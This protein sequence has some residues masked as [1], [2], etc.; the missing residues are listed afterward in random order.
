VQD[1]PEGIS[2]E[3]GSRLAEILNQRPVAVL[4][5]SI[6]GRSPY[7]LGN[8]LRQLS[9]LPL[10]LLNL[11]I[12]SLQVGRARKHLFFQLVAR[13]ANC[14]FRAFLRGTHNRDRDGTENKRRKKALRLLRNC[15]RVQGRNKKVTDQQRREQDR[16]S[17]GDHAPEPHASHDCAKK[18][19]DERV[20]DDVLQQECPQQRHDDP[21]KRDRSGL[22]DA[23][24]EPIL[25]AISRQCGHGPS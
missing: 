11:E 6:G 14:I 7:L 10:A 8:R 21:G 18:Q 23:R 3:I 16:N 13:L 20:R 5:F 4:H 22:D 25:D 24:E 2:L 9:Q 19:K 12:R 15:H 1:I 17:P